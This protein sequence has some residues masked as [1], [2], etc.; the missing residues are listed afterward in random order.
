VLMQPMCIATCPQRAQR[1][2]SG[3]I[4]VMASLLGS[5]PTA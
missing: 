4:V 2:C 5:V 1:I 3:S